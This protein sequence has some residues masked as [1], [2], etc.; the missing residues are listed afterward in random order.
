MNL[1]FLRRL[2]LVLALLL[3]FNACSDD[4]DSGDSGTNPD[5]NPNP[6]PTPTVVKEVAKLTLEGA[7]SMRIGETTEVI[8]HVYDQDNVEWEVQE[9]IDS[10]ITINFTAS[11]NDVTILKKTVNTADVTANTYNTLFTISAN[12][13]SVQSQNLVSGEIYP[14]ITKLV[15]AYV[16]YGNNVDTY[17]IGFIPVVNQ[18]NRYDLQGLESEG[19][20][21]IYYIEGN[22]VK[23][24]EQYAG[25]KSFTIATI[26]NGVITKLTAQLGTT[27]Y[28]LY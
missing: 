28:E 10:S 25:V 9:L 12:A 14:D 6:N 23:T 11:S 19:A 24:N 15:S 22:T 26:E 13:G 7:S 1:K 2:T 18:D 21:G 3:T 5:P 27:S 16:T 4:D 17:A 20:F 8:A